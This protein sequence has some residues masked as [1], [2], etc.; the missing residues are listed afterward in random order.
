MTGP[1]GRSASRAG[2]VVRKDL[3]VLWA[4]PLPY[5]VAALLHGV[6][7]VLVVNQLQA[8]DQAVIQPLFPIA[9]FLL[10][11]TVPVLTMRSFSEESRTGTL[12][13]LQA[14]PVRARPLVIGK[15]LAAWVTALLV[16]APALL[17]A[18]LL[19]WWG[20]PDAGPV[21]AGFV[22]LA[23][24]TGTLAAL[25]VLMSSMTSSQPV[26]AMLAVFAELLLWFS[27]VGSESLSTGSLLA[28]FSLSERLRTFAGGG[29]DTADIGFFSAV[30]MA[31]L[32]LAGGVVDGRRLR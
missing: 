28:H 13:L 22:G 18:L 23:L 16:L 11:L 5:V 14:V 31:A 25:G 24:L 19:E 29:I 26:A 2:A 8:A 15:W 30:A 32:V 7:G 17:F 12:E 27:H 3:T 9:G 1:G 21:V 10:L 20:D 6:M 4:S